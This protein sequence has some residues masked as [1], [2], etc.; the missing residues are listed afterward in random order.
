MCRPLWACWVA[1][2]SVY[3]V[4]GEGSHNRIMK[5]T[6]T[7]T[8]WQEYT[9]DL[10]QPNVDWRG[11]M[12]TSISRFSIIRKAIPFECRW[13]KER[14]ALWQPRDSNFY[15]FEEL[16][17]RD[18][19]LLANT[20]L[21]KEMGTPEKLITWIDAAWRIYGEDQLGFMR[22][23]QTK[24]DMQEEPLFVAMMD[25]ITPFARRGLFETDSPLSKTLPP[26]RYFSQWADL[27]SKPDNR[28][29]L[30]INE[31]SAKNP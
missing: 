20:Q 25:V 2:N 22:G 30:W 13:S 4:L 10:P 11:M 23:L 1:Q 24:P 28:I 15:K 19:Y 26:R 27:F 12:T 5:R 29:Q 8:S 7:P 16:P 3:S 18:H 9:F 21:D 17:I 31:K 6:R 14:E